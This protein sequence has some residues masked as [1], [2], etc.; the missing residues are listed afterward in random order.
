MGLERLLDVE[1]RHAH[2]KDFSPV[3]IDIFVN[4]L[5]PILQYS[6]ISHGPFDLVVLRRAFV[7][8]SPS[9]ETNIS[10]VQRDIYIFE[11]IARSAIDL[12]NFHGE[13]VHP[14]NVSVEDEVV[15]IFPILAMLLD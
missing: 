2:E 6:P 10:S 15:H 14:P 13:S 9:A 11:V 8:R 5:S 1:R 4:P 3:W 12:Q 7:E